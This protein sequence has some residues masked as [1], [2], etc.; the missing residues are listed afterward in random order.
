MMLLQHAL[1]SDEGLMRMFK[2]LN[3][4]LN[5]QLC[6][7]SHNFAHPEEDEQPEVQQNDQ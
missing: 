3:R 4:K 7:L 1:L 5:A 6:E 2:R